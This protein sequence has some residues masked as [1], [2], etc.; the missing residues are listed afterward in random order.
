MASL[1]VTYCKK[2]KRDSRLYYAQWMPITKIELGSVG[3]L[4]DGVVYVEKTTL[5]DQGIDF[6]V[7]DDPS[8]SP[9]DLLSSR[10]TKIST[11]AAGEVSTTMPSVPQA[12]AGITVE[13]DS[14]A[15][16]VIKAA[17][18]YEP[19]LSNVARL[20]QEIL[21]RFR[22]GEWRR[23]W[24]VISQLVTTPAASILISQTRKSRVEITAEGQA[25][26]GQRVELGNAS[27]EFQVSSQSGQVYNFLNT[28]NVTPLFQLIGIKRRPLGGVRVETRNAVID[29]ASLIDADLERIRGDDELFSMLHLDAV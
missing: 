15:A 5:R 7:I 21:D 20:E 1:A 27:F 18:S 26:V 25:N 19:R 28:E 12:K 4:V 16:Y 13:F 8:S 2:V 14:Q 24:V 23:E 6:D 10:E 9:L 3:V 22:R 17:Q 11:K 29:T